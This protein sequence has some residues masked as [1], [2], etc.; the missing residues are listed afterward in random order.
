SLDRDPG[1]VL[2]V[3]ASYIALECA[4]FLRHLGHDVTVAVRSILLRGF[5]QQCAEK[6]GEVMAAQGTRFVRPSVA[7]QIVKDEDGRLRVT[8]VETRS[9]AIVL[10]DVFDTVL[11]ATGRAPD[12][13]G[14]GLDSAGVEVR[15]DGKI[16]VTNEQ[17]NVPSI[18]AL[19][20][21]S[22]VDVVFANSHWAN[23]ELTPIAIKA[24]ELWA[25]R[26][27]GGA[28]KMMDYKLAAT[29]IF[30]PV[31]YGVCGL[32]EEDAERCYGKE[33]IETYLF[34]FSSLE[35]QA[36]HRRPHGEGREDEDMPQICVSKLVCLKNEEEKVVGFHFVGPNAGEITQ[37]F[38]LAL[39]LGAKK[40]DFD[41]MVG[42]H[43]T[44]AESFAAMSIT[45]ASGASFVAAGGC[46]GGVCG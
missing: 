13:T 29:T 34:E 39:R 1:K 46:G 25:S 35:L 5:D 17:T 42:I 44:D 15:A 18:H 19:G 43:P 6:I 2:V 16:P 28:K 14:L 7:S 26:L 45:R 22:V 36:A 24:G 27:F 20:D 41:D 38:A 3:G 9:R 37:G 31:E 33:N 8:L 40:A 30:T 32:S 4:G 21:C 12:T 10:E 11:Y 23:P